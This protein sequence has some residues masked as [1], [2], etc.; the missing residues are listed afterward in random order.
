[1]SIHS[2]HLIFAPLSPQIKKQQWRRKATFIYIEIFSKDIHEDNL[3]NL[4]RSSLIELSYIKRE[5]FKPLYSKVLRF[6]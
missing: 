5:G 3:R 6:F 4:R 1:M 2:L